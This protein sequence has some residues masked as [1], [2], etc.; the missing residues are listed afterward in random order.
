MPPIEKWAVTD[1]CGEFPCTAPENIV[2][3]FEGNSFEGSR[4]SGFDTNTIITYG[5][6]DE[7]FYRGCDYRESQ[8]AWYCANRDIG[9]LLFESLDGDTYDRS[10]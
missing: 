1:D 4:P 7:P 8:N 2:L 9:V 10:V 6:S 3:D 5:F